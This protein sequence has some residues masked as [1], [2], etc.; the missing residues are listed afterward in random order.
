MKKKKHLGS[1]VLTGLLTIYSLSAHATAVSIADA[2][3]YSDSLTINGQTADILDFSV[4][5]EV[6][7]S[8][9]TIDMNYIDGDNFDSYL[10][11]SGINISAVTGY[12]DFE[13]AY[14]ATTLSD[15]ISTDIKPASAEAFSLIY[16]PLEADASEEFSIGFFYDLFVS[17][18]ALAV[19]EF[20]EAIASISFSLLDFDFNELESGL[21]DDL[22]VNAAT[23]FNFPDTVLGAF[24]YTFS[25]LSEGDEY[26]LAI[27]TAAF[28]ST[29]AHAVPE[30]PGLLLALMGLIFLG[31]KKVFNLKFNLHGVSNE[32]S[33]IK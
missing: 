32:K 7:L 17:V 23:S 9:D 2:I 8:N 18:E 14:V 20:S 1:L 4:D 33:I 10:E 19:G 12:D 5:A 29:E 22:I 26:Y 11:K 13:A 24:D 16:I 15:S 28:S 30:P 31:R 25:G 27:Q 3:F 21:S 6:F